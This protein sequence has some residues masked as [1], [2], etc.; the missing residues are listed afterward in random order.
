MNADTLL[1]PEQ[2]DELIIIWRNIMNSKYVDPSNP[3]TMQEYIKCYQKGRGET[4]KLYKPGTYDFTNP[5]T[6]YK[7]HW[8]Q[9]ISFIALHDKLI[10]IKGAKRRNKDR[11]SIV[12]Q[13]AKYLRRTPTSADLKAAFP[14]LT[15]LNKDISEVIDKDLSSLVV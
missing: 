11:R 8:E 9:Y 12:K 5:E 14:F 13:L 1:R 7:E 10:N 2:Q 3:P 4:S 6:L 15:E